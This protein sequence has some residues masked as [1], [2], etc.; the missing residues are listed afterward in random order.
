MVRRSATSNRLKPVWTDAQIDDVIA[1]LKTLD[2][3]YQKPGQ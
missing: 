3:A 1:F 2:D